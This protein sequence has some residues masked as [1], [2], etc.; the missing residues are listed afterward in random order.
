MGLAN[1]EWAWP[2]NAIILYWHFP[3]A[4]HR[5]GNDKL[6]TRA[7]SFQE[8]SHTKLQSRLPVKSGSPTYVT[9]SISLL[10]RLTGGYA[11]VY[12]S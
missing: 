6:C 4:C 11:K 2:Y 3:V 7:F 12:L 8:F 10:I 5:E 9:E 1:M